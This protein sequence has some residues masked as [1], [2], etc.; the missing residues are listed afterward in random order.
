M[1][2]YSHYGF[3]TV[4]TDT[5]HNSTAGDGSWALNE[6]ERI[7]DWGYRAMHSS[8]QIAKKVIAAYYSDSHPDANTVQRS[9]YAGC[10][11]GG[12]QGLKEIEMYPEDFDG[13]LAGAPAWWTNHLQTWTTYI[14]QQNLPADKP[15][16]VSAEQYTA[17]VKEFMRQCDGQDGLDDQIIMTPDKC[18]FDVN[19]LSCDS[20]QVNKSTC[21]TDA[22][23][24]TLE[25]MIHPYIAPDGTFVFPGF[26]PGADATILTTTANPL[27][28]GFLQ[29]FVYNDTSYSYTSFSYADVLAADRANPGQATANNF[30]LSAFKNRGGK[31]IMYHGW[32]DPLIP[33]WSSDYFYNAAKSTMAAINLDDFFRLFHIPGMGHCAGNAGTMSAPWYIGAANQAIEG[34]DYSVPGYMDPKHDAV[35]ALIDWVEN[36]IPPD[37]IIATKFYNDT[38]SGGVELQRPLCPLPN[39]AKFSGSGDWHQAETWTCQ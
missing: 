37:A 24:N 38:L 14:A 13:V 9:Y 35:L 32:A 16:H 10:S 25:K 33:N 6:P 29:W 7:I 12:R 26:A 3:A 18:Q 36:G 28:Y 31:L 20:G 23:L 5:G 22:Q 17:Y 27:G 21:F 11:T 15:A 39:V 8:V 30:D 19:T 1:A 4:S 34:V 2:T